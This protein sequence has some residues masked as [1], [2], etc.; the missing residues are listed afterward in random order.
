MQLFVVRHAVAYDADPERWPDDRDRPLTA[1]GERAF[2]GVARAL[3]ALTDAAELV[4]ASPYAR[5]WRTAELLHEEA[6]WPKA[7]SLQALESGRPA[8]EAVDALAAWPAVERL[9][10]VGHEP[11][12][13]R[14]SAL[15]I[16]GGRLDLRKGAL[17]W[18]EVAEMTP[19][20]A[21]LRALLQPKLIR[22]LRR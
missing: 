12:L 21:T 1:D 5:A 2:R 7:R 17:A 18:L 15:L 16:G 11:M 3:R 6:G 8:R 9:A 13:S 14:L 4:L 19:G 10:I 22:R 20:G